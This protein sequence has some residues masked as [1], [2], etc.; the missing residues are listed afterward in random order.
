[1]P[2]IRTFVALKKFLARRTILQNARH[3]EKRDRKIRPLKGARIGILFMAGT[4]SE[5]QQMEKFR[6]SLVREGAEVRALG[7]IPT[8]VFPSDLV[9]KPGFDYFNKKETS[10]IG[11]A[12]NHVLQ[13]FNGPELD[14]IIGAFTDENLLL[15]QFGAQN[16]KAFRVGPYLQKYASCFDFMIDTQGNTEIKNLLTLTEHYLKQLNA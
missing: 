9:F 5:R 11:L 6:D 12:H 15:L 1:M 10:W 14:C 7:Y 3:S 2:G 16:K 13:K 8:K 4:P